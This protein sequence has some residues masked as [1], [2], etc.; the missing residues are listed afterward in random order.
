[1]KKKVCNY[2]FLSEKLTKKLWKKIKIKRRSGVLCPLFS[3]YSKK[4][5]GVGEFRDLKIVVDWCEETGHSILQLLP[6]NDLAADNSPYSATS[7]FAID[8]LYLSL[9]EIKGKKIAISEELLKLQNKYPL[10]DK[11]FKINYA[12]KQDKLDLL[13]KIFE[14]AK[15]DFKAFKDFKKTN[16]FWLEDYAIYKALKNVNDGK[17]WDNWT[18]DFK[19]KN[20]ES[21]DKIKI[22]FAKNIEFF[23][24][25]QWQAF[26]QLKSVKD[27]AAEKNVLIMGDIPFLVA[28]D[29]A[30]VW[31]KY[32]EI[33]NLEIF[34][35]CPPD[36][37]NSMGQ[38]WGMPGYNWERLRETKYEYFAKKL[39]YAENFY[40]MYRIDHVVGMFRLWT[41]SKNESEENV[42]LNGEFDPRDQ[43]LWR[44]NG[45][46]ILKKMI[47]SSIMLPCAEDL[48]VVP[49]ESIETLERF[50]IPGL[51]VIRWSK[52]R[53]K[54]PRY[55][56]AKENLR[57]IAC[58]ISSSHDTSNTFCLIESEFGTIDEQTFKRLCAQK[59]I[60]F[61]HLAPKLFALE[62]SKNGR[63]KFLDEI[64]TNDLFLWN[65]G[66]PV[67]EVGELLDMYKEAFGEKDLFFKNAV[68]LD[69][70]FL[71]KA[72]TSDLVWKTLEYLSK[73]ASIFFINSILDIMLLE[74]NSDDY[75]RQRIN[76][77]GTVGSHNWTWRMPFSVEKLTKMKINENLEAL[78]K[79][80]SR[81]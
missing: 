34:A 61:D 70:K 18:E 9:P 40:D 2:D 39:K 47:E 42:A 6:V 46:D 41:I 63:L 10:S 75:C 37:Y 22:E 31:G 66:R 65:L 20:Q 57:P 29:S 55:F 12:V 69:E 64:N 50:G 1:M 24:W 11:K 48:G 23:K 14:T 35:G 3:I 53:T 58:A 78:N 67:S 68:G 52:D 80:G 73:S 62:N 38:K 8:P 26:E 25:L 17:S 28:K 72:K 15:L 45:E 33:F 54:E 7:S 76:M 21:I 77:P 81:C 51:D 32:N 59:N 74:T 43:N 60:N 79:A 4:S 44:K 71:K 49:I 19:N 36:A 56:K 5:V 13:M 27:Y 16:D 30:D